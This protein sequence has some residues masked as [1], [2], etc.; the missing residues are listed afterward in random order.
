[1]KKIIAVIAFA[2]VGN[3]AMAQDTFKQD[4][5]EVLKL[6]GSAAQ[7]E[8]AKEQIIGNIPADKQEAFSKEFDATLPSFYEKLAKV[9]MEI[10]TKE[11]IADMKK[12]YTSR[13][14][15]KMSENSGELM[16]KS[17]EA[18]QEWGMEL[19]GM[20]MKFME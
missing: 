12:F 5:L 18:G 10:Y 11:D 9:Y 1:M 19:Q 2:V 17:Q 20:M 13:V 14:G 6:S 3:F 4:V 15:K 16:K 8:M 7:L